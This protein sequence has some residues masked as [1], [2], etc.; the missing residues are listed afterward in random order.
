MFQLMILLLRERWRRSD[1]Q[2]GRLMQVSVYLICLVVASVATFGAHQ[3]AYERSFA[4]VAIISNELLVL[5]VVA[6]VLTDTDLTWQVRLDRLT[7]F[8]LTFE[9]IHMLALML[10]FLSFPLLLGVCAVEITFFDRGV[11]QIGWLIKL[12]AYC[13][14]V[15]S[16]S[17]I[18]SLVRTAIF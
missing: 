6:V 10:R 11:L 12:S 9:R 14:L 8:P 17:S 1:A 7:I 2:Y 4:Q 18:V 13:L 5:W 15:C 16:V 3:L